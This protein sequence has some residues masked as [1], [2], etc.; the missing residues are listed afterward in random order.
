MARKRRKKRKLEF[1]K[2]ILVFETVLVAYVSHRVLGFVGRAIELDYTGSLPYLTTFISA[3]WAAYGTSVSFYQSKSGKENIKKIEI[4]PPV[5]YA[6]KEAIMDTN[7]IVQLIV[8]ILTGLATCIPLAVKLVEYVKTAT[9]EKNWANLLGLVMSLMEQAEKKFDDGAT[10]KEWVMAMVKA[11]A[12]YI[13]YPVDEDTLSKMIDSLC[14]MSK[15]VNG[16]NTN[17]T[18]TTEQ[19]LKSPGVS[20][21]MFYGGKN[22]EVPTE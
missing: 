11:S 22:L 18:I 5:S 6:R 9:K 2:L 1:S 16:T 20:G 4:A 8:A 7:Q 15:V 10:R 21:A 17:Q 19:T 13:N 12:D 14:D 3:V